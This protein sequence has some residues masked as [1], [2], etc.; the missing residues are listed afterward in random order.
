MTSY[1]LINILGLT[2]NIIGSVILIY[3]LQNF[4]TSLHGSVAIHDMQIKSIVNKENQILSADVANLLSAGAKS[5]KKRTMTGLLI[6]IAG[7]IFQ[8]LPYLF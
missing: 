6:I 5:G 2:L 1:T 3:S 7:F 4:F 8:I